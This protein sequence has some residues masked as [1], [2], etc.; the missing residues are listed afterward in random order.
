MPMAKDKLVRDYFQTNLWIVGAIIIPGERLWLTDMAKRRRVDTFPRGRFRER[1]PNWGRRGL[2]SALTFRT[3]T[4]SSRGASGLIMCPCGSD[5]CAGLQDADG[6]E[7]GRSDMDKVAVGRENALRLLRL[8]RQPHGLKMGATARELGVGG[9]REWRACC[10]GAGILSH[11]GAWQGDRSTPTRPRNCGA[12]LEGESIGEGV[13]HIRVQDCNGTGTISGCKDWTG[14]WTGNTV[15]HRPSRD[16][17]NPDGI[18]ESVAVHLPL[19]REPALP[20]LAAPVSTRRWALALECDPTAQPLLLRAG[21]SLLGLFL[22][23]DSFAVSVLSRQPFSCSVRRL[24]P[25]PVP[26]PSITS[27]ALVCGKRPCVSSCLRFFC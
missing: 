11:A 21:S 17:P 26:D 19:Y 5:A 7:L 15:P 25:R 20:G 6:P 3:R 8:D 22:L 13:G 14:P 9:L 23:V 24:R 10:V 12:R 2:R 4:A 27:S 16:R 1:S 18:T